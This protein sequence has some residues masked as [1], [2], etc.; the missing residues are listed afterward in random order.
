[1][2]KSM[3]RLK[4][5]ADKNPLVYFCP[6]PPQEAWLRDK[7][8]IKLLLGGNQVGKTMAACAELLHRCLGTHPWLKT[9]PPKFIISPI[10]AITRIT[11]TTFTYV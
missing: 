3:R 10:K 9:D 6:T 8:K 5:R 2:A 1:M 4:G 7:S 11:L